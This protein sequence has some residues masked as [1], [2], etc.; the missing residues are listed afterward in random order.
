M[1]RMSR[2]APV[3]VALN[4]ESGASRPVA[5]R[6]QSRR[7]RGTGQLAPFACLRWKRSS[8]AHCFH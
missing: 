7:G 3:A 1:G 6:L 8:L 2:R 5:L 4:S